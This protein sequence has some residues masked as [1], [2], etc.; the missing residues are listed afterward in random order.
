VTVLDD[1]PEKARALATRDCT[2]EEVR[3]LWAEA[4][5][6]GLVSTPDPAAGPRPPWETLEAQER[7]ERYAGIV[8]RAHEGRGTLM[9]R[10]VCDADHGANPKRENVAHIYKSPSG[11]LFEAS[12]ELLDLKEVVHETPG[13]TRM[14]WWDHRVLLDCPIASRPRRTNSS[15]VTAA[16]W[17]ADHGALALDEDILVAAVAQYAVLSRVQVVRVHPHQH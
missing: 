17:C 2:E 1:Y 8:Q 9:V 16:A 15:P 13:H 3:E 7:A 11:P 5:A 12:R 4:R 10:V 14:P 6:A